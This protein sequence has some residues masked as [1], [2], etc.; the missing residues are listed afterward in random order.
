MTT[1]HGQSLPSISKPRPVKDE[2]QEDDYFFTLHLF[3]CPKNSRTNKDNISGAKNYLIRDGSGRTEQKGCPQSWHSTYT[4]Y[5]NILKNNFAKNLLF[6][7]YL[8][9]LQ[10]MQVFS[11]KSRKREANYLVHVICAHHPLY[12]H[13]YGQGWR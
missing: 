11:S 13:E 10:Y 8:N 7:S 9:L 12:F 2:M 6:S 4:Q 5:V 3:A 1:V